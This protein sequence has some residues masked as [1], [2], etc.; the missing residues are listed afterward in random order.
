MT[1][2][3]QAYPGP[4]V[5]V[6]VF[7]CPSPSASNACRS[8]YD[9]AFVPKGLSVPLGS[10]GSEREITVLTSESEL[11][12]S[13]LRPQVNRIVGRLEFLLGVDPGE[14]LKR[15]LYL[16]ALK[17]ELRLLLDAKNKL[18]RLKGDDDMTLEIYYT[19]LSYPDL[20]PPERYRTEWI[21]CPRMSEGRL[22]RVFSLLIK[23]GQFCQGKSAR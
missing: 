12:F 9:T 8:R 20:F 23:L 10:A 7:L 16:S 5:R 19:Y 22:A 2:S 6:G 14:V 18:D 3:D 4:D 17:T 21:Q 13:L 11:E 1:R 15:G